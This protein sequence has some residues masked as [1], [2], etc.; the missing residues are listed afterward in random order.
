MNEFKQ[1]ISELICNSNMGEVDFAPKKGIVP[2]SAKISL[3]SS[4]DL[5]LIYDAIPYYCTR[6]NYQVNQLDHY[7]Q[8][9]AQN[10][11]SVSIILGHRMKL[12]LPICNTE[13]LMRLRF[14][15]GRTAIDIDLNTERGSIRSL[16]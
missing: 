13:K 11:I 14:I 4:G 8:D 5:H 2:S 15:K 3:S 7:D 1:M 6:L 12:A 16:S 10:N 9:Q